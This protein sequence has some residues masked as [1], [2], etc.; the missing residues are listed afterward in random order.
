LVYTVVFVVEI[1]PEG[2]IPISAYVISVAPSVS[3][4]QAASGPALSH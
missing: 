2:P 3:A 4:A 1:I